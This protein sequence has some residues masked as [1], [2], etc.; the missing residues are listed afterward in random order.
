MMRWQIAVVVT[1]AA[2]LHGSTSPSG[3][4]VR[5]ATESEHTLQQCVLD[6]DPAPELRE[7]VIAFARENLMSDLD[8]LTKY[9]SSN[10]TV[11][12]PLEPTGCNQPAHPDGYFTEII[13]TP[14][15]KLGKLVLSERQ[16]LHGKCEWGADVVYCLHVT[17]E[18]SGTS[19][20]VERVGSSIG[21]RQRQR[22]RQRPVDHRVYVT[23]RGQL[24]TR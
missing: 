21:Q 11:E 9:P 19:V 14:R 7:P 12:T 6:G 16:L 1:A 15:A 2:C 8:R 20:V 10:F 3:I 23:D 18:R 4:R 17:T 13:V 24:P 22:Q 5:L